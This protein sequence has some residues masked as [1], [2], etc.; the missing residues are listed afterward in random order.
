MLETKSIRL[1]SFA[2]FMELR[3]LFWL[4]SSRMERET[5]LSVKVESSREPSC[6]RALRMT[7]F[8][9]Y[10]GRKPRRCTNTLRKYFPRSYTPRQMENTILKLLEAW[11]K[12]RQRSQE[13]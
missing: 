4:N 10:W 13:R 3:M 6:W 12:K 1:A 11:T 8:L 5:P 2:F 9:Q 7:L